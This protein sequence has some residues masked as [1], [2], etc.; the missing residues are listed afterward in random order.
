MML[1]EA[2]KEAWILKT[3]ISVGDA[4]SGSRL[5]IGMA[6][7]AICLSPARADDD[8][9]NRKIDAAQRI[10]ACS[11][12]IVS[13]GLGAAAKSRALNNRGRMYH[14]L[15]DFDHALTDFDDAIRAD[16]ANADAFNNRG[17]LH[18][19]RFED[20]R[21]FQDWDEALRVSPRAEYFLNRGK[22]YSQLGDS[23]HAIADFGQAI[24]LDSRLVAAFV[25]RADVYRR[26]KDFVRAMR[27]YDQAL[28]IDP[29]NTQVPTLKRELH[30]GYA[31]H[32]KNMNSYI[33][34][35]LVLLRTQTLFPRQALKEHAEGV[36]RV[37]FAINRRGSAT[38]MRIAV[39]S[40][41]PI[42]D[43]DALATIQRAQP[44]PPLPGGRSQQK[45]A[46]PIRFKANG[47]PVPEP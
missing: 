9:D 37:I 40:G 34:A 10:E 14:R 18:W 41:F 4:M 28:Q 21:A 46:L 47:P 32:P 33:Q 11:A 31:A 3:S 26:K 43:Q 8:C 23:D 30:D 1:G 5:V 17:N 20:D 39:S 36:A 25:A 2:R 6:M 22:K 19:A 12:V 42:L 44:F 29:A 38:E 27:D 13:D 35:V 16:P 7:A 15:K 45:F 24:T